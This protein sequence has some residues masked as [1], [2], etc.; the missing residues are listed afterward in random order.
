MK[1]QTVVFDTDSAYS[2]STGVFTVPVAG[3]YRFKAQI[4]FTGVVGNCRLDIQQNGTNIVRGFNNASLTGIVTVWACTGRVCAVNDAIRVALTFS[5]PA[6][7][8]GDN[9]SEFEGFLLY[10]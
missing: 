3:T 1:C 6:T 2:T 10:V 4:S 9:S 7:V 8:N 5:G